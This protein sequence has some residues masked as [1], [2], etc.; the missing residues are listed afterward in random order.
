MVEQRIRNVLNGFIESNWVG[1]KETKHL[2]IGHIFKLGNNLVTWCYKKQ[3]IGFF[4]S[5]EASTR[6]SL[7]NQGK[8]LVAKSSSRIQSYI[9][10]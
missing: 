6:C 4:S 7:R 3:S 8:N 1:D 5:I 2:T 9:F 10:M